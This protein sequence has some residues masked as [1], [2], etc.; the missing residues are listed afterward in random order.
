MFVAE[1]PEDE[2]FVEVTDG[3]DP[4]DL[5]VASI[6]EVYGASG[7]VD[8]QGQRA[9][10]AG[11]MADALAEGYSGIRVAADNSTLVTTPGRID[12]WIRW[13]LVADRFMAENHVTGP[14]AFNRDR[15]D[16]DLLRHLSTLHPSSSAE[17][18]IPSSGS[19][20][21]RTGA[22]I[23]GEVDA[24]AVEHLWLALE[25]LPRG[26]HVIVDHT[27]ATLRGDGVRA[28]LRRLS[29][30]GVHV[31]LRGTRATADTHAGSHTARQERG[32]GAAI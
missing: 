24:F 31:S 26:T 13:E 18:P 19:S 1:N 6:S 20:W 2:A 25:A 17:F 16:I 29:E 32:L 8:A 22:C 28:D 15:V 23:E 21:T 14:C 9:T 10:F 5:Q 3:L 11:T 4:A 27:Q 7:V 12:A 30:S